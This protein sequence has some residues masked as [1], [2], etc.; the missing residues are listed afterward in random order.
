MAYE[1]DGTS[2]TVTDYID[3]DTDRVVDDCPDDQPYVRVTHFPWDTDPN[4]DALP[5]VEPIPLGEQHEVTYWDPTSEME[6][7]D[8]DD[9][10][11]PVIE[12]HY[13]V[14]GADRACELAKDVADEK[15]VVIW[16]TITRLRPRV[17][18]TD[19]GLPDNETGT[20]PADQSPVVYDTIEDDY[21]LGIRETDDGDWIAI[22]REHGE[23]EKA[24]TRDDA[25][26]AVRE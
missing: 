20:D 23:W 10:V 15:D 11:S 7:A 2:G 5:D 24:D 21:R 18:V 19:L 14:A 25:L 8:R 9:P 12:T 3:I 6:L 4:D 26:A 17:V 13:R 22:N 16:N 1:R